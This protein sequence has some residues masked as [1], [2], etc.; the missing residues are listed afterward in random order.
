MP[1]INSKTGKIRKNYSVE[2]LTKKA[3]EM[4]AYNVIAITA[5]GS[6]HIGVLSPL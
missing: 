6:G 2:Q 4:R 1:I 5:T 3:Q